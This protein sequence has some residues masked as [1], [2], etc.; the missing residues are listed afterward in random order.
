MRCP[1]P[2]T[3]TAALAAG[4]LALACSTEGPAAPD[5]GAGQ[6]VPASGSLTVT[7]TPDLDV[8][9]APPSGGGAAGQVSFRQPPDEH[10]TV[11]LGVQ[12]TGLAPNTDYRLQ[13]ATDG[14]ADGICTSTSWLTLGRGSAPQA[15]TTD[16]S[17]AGHAALFRD[18]TAPEGTTND[19]HFQVIDAVTGA[20]VLQSGC[21]QFVVRR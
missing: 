2:F 19:I 16:A 21:Y 4:L 7:P 14:P 8:T 11:L 17:G 6:N 20:V 1:I 9:L 12:V 15:I 5:T 13:R 3:A 10:N 18:L